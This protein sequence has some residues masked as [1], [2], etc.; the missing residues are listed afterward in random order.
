MIRHGKTGSGKIGQGQARPGNAGLASRGKERPGKVGLGM[1][2]V[3]WQEEARSGEARS[4]EVRHENTINIK[5]GNQ[6]TPKTATALKQSIP[7]SKEVKTSELVLDFDFYPRRTVDSQHTSYIAAAIEAGAQMPPIIACAKTKRVADGFHRIRAVESLF[8]TNATIEVIFKRYTNDTALFRDA[9]QLNS[10]HGR[11]LTKYDRT[12]CALLANKLN[13]SIKHVAADLGMAEKKVAILLVDRTAS[14]PLRVAID[15]KPH[16]G[17][18][19]QPVAYGKASKGKQ[20]LIPLKRTIA[21]MSG[22]AL[23]ADQIA[24]NDKL[25]GMNQTFYVN[26]LITLFQSGLINRDNENLIARLVVLKDILT[27]EI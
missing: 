4:G 7:K 25:S 10:N 23:S 22:K 24:A 21:H 11:A 19:R 2:G 27:K 14:A 26:Q 17:E 12:H 18:A 3:K 6:M 8:G 16:E 1:A 13:I 15:V 20:N 9:M 5:E